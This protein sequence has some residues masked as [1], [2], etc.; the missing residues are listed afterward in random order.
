MNITDQKT[1]FDLKQQSKGAVGTAEQQQLLP[2]TKFV[3]QVAPLFPRVL[4]II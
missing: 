1:Q 2:E 4:C 3:E